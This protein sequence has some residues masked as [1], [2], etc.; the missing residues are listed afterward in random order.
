M[1]KLV[2]LASM[3]VLLCAS[4]SF[5]K[6]ALDEEEMDLITA[7]GQPSIIDIEVTTTGVTQAAGSTQTTSEV[8]SVLDSTDQ[9]DL[10][11]S[12]AQAVL[13]STAF[14]GG[15]G[16]DVDIPFIPIDILGSAAL[17]VD[18]SDADI[19]S[20]SLT[21]AS[22]TTGSLTATASASASSSMSGAIAS[23]TAMNQDSSQITLLV[24]SGSQSELRAMVVNNIV[25]ENQLAAGINI[26]SGAASTDN[27]STQSNE[28]TQSWGST[29]D[30]TFAEGSLLATATPAVGGVNNQSNTAT[31]DGGT[32]GGGTGGAISN[33]QKINCILIENCN[34]STAGTGGAGEGGQA[35]NN[36]A[37]AG[38]IEGGDA[39]AAVGVLQHLP[40]T[41]AADKISR[42]R[43]NSTGDA[44]VDVS[45]MDSSTVT[46]IVQSDSQTNL[47]ALVV[48]NI[49]GKNQIASAFNV[50]ANGAVKIGDANAVPSVL[51]DGTVNG[52]AIF[53]GGQS[54]EI[55]QFRGTPY[56]QFPPAP[57]GP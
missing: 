38:N 35:D 52:L 31:A 36:Q 12:V 47:A 34:V 41:I 18:F 27:A 56:Q 37:V 1:K 23:V 49:G 21:V 42:V 40:L 25:G 54:N 51:F 20:F 24:A 53:G 55:N 14:A 33:V 32:G 9:S 50:A 13:D 28:I 2:A 11:N 45:E 29:Y 46:V 44:Y 15:L 5:A 19:N 10:N 39:A 3:A 30:W 17:N 26:R 43:V 8:S 22:G 6:K 57:V 48:N 4:A 16:L 7:A